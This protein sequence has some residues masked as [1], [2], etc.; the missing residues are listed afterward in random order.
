[1]GTDRDDDDQPAPPPRPFTPTYQDRPLSHF[2]KR[3]EEPSED[4][5]REASHPHDDDE[6]R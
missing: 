4:A 5:D 6:R 3:F 1:M 2:E